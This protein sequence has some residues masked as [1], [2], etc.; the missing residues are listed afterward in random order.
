MKENLP[1]SGE[2]TSIV[3]PTEDEELLLLAADAAIEA[4]DA[5]L[6]LL[7]SFGADDDTLTQDVL[8][9]E[10]S[11]L[12]TGR[13]RKHTRIRSSWSGLS[14]DIGRRLPPLLLAVMMMMIASPFLYCIG[15]SY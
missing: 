1:S 9:R 7:L 15:S 14:M 12:F 5:L 3:L 4:Y 10:V 6:L 2:V 13:R 8:L 11:N